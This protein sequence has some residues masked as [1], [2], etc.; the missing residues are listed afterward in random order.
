MNGVWTS[1]DQEN[2]FIRRSNIE[3]YNIDII[4]EK[5]SIVTKN[6]SLPNIEEISRKKVYELDEEFKK[7]DMGMFEPHGSIARSIHDDLSHLTEEATKELGKITDALTLTYPSFMTSIKIFRD[8]SFSILS[9]NYKELCTK[10]QEY[11][12]KDNL[13]HLIFEVHRDNRYW[14]MVPGSYIEA[15]EKQKKELKQLGY[16]DFISENEA[17]ISKLIEMQEKKSKDFELEEAKKAPKKLSDEEVG[18]ELEKLRK[19]KEELEAKYAE[20]EIMTR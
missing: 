15:W 2:E 6:D 18:I 9:K 19:Q 11:T 13:R 20:E 3:I 14:I 4:V 17:S 5:I 16:E 7:Q 1:N 12:I 10:T 8:K